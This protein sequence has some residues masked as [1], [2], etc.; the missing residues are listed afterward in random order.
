MK[1]HLLLICA[2][3]LFATPVLAKTAKT[4][5]TPVA[6]V[7]PIGSTQIPA[8]SA[9]PVSSA[10]PVAVTTTAPV[11][12]DTPAAAKPKDLTPDKVTAGDLTL[13][14]M[15][16]NVKG[17]DIEFSMNVKNNSKAAPDKIIGI[18]ADEWPATS[19][20]GPDG[21]ELPNV[22]ISADGK[23]DVKFL[24]KGATSKQIKTSELPITFYFSR[25]PNTKL[26]VYIVGHEGIGSKIMG[27]FK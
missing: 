6:A 9:T 16:A 3:A 24:I 15:Q 1:K 27:I 10:T 20:T 13:T 19:I 17:G 18:A 12:D 4:S 23:A 8:T 5:D 22:V 7:T 26:K 25:G 21:K 2:C 14:G 11:E